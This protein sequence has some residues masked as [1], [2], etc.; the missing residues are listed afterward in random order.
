MLNSFPFYKQ[1][2]M[3]DCGPSCLRMIAKYHGKSY[4]LTELRSK[5]FIN[6][7][8]VSMLGISDAAEAIGF[9]TLGVKIPFEKLS[10]D[11]PLPCIVH[12][13]QNHFAVVYCIK[14]NKVWVAD[15][16]AGLLTY[17][18]D[19]FL[20][21]WLS[22]SSNGR[23]EGVALLLETTP[24]FYRTEA[25]SDL[26]KR[27]GFNYLLGYLHSYR[28]FIVQL[29]IGLLLG[30]L[31]QLILPFLTQSVVDVG[32][33]TRNVPFIYMVLAGQLMLFIGRTVA[34]FLRRWI[35]L[36]LSTR[37]NL[38]IIS[39]F[40]IKL[41]Q[42]P[43]GFFDSKKI[44]D[45]LQRI[46]DHSRIERFLSSSSL[47]ILFSFFNLIVFGV[48]LA[49]Y[50]IPIFLIFFIASSLYVGYVMLFLKMRKDQDYKRFN[51]LSRNRSSL[52]QLVNGMQEIKLNNAE[53]EKRWEWER[54]QVNLFQLNIASTRLQQWQEGGSLFI[55]ELKNIF[56]TFL[57]A[58]AVISGSMTLG[59]MLAVQYIIGQ[60]NVPINEFVNFIRELQDARI[61]LDR[62]GE[63]RLLEN[64]E[65]EKT[66][67]YFSS[68]LRE[69]G[70]R[71]DEGTIFLRNLSYQYD[72][73]HSP[74][75]L[76]GV[77]LI[78]EQGKVTAIVGASGSG[79]TTLL[80][81]LLK[82]YPPNEG[83]LRIGK[84]DLQQHSA[85]EWRARCGTVM[86]DGFIFSDSIARNICVGEE[87]IDTQRL[88]HAATVANIHEF[89]E[90]LPLGYN[91]KIG[92]DGVG[93]SAGQKQRLLIARAVYKNPDYIFFDEAT[94]ALDANNERVIM[95]N[96]NEFF[97]GKTVVVIAHRLS[98]VKNAD[99]IVVLD[100]GK[101]IEQ[102]THEEL[103]LK[104]G[105]YFELVKNQLELGN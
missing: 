33:N 10:T 12:W 77:D 44:G 64:E 61:S 73:P 98:T 18:K 70:R 14:K 78:I 80:K 32:I 81:L 4:S 95:D 1:L 7:E 74:K 40:L 6:R 2:D 39:D 89:V 41:M 60:L 94:S 26:N 43:M 47:S 35:L 9:R 16:A 34:E 17:T 25:A 99:K 51:I 46:E 22:T 55:N 93:I 105:S 52:I 19:E 3:M 53:R 63:I 90:S 38:S 49:L 68:P 69:A 31:I 50:N 88:L 27:T 96:L 58:T 100:K 48:V 91:T 87:N 24:T 21:C 13:N 23:S 83:E 86:Q 57:A 75:A 102:G 30:S 103:A 85:R 8:G 71:L 11:A 29:L 92:A 62:I 37:I 101:L 82:F 20:K 42:L 54:I 67:G 84:T 79:K 76:D 66:L 65:K 59:M 45:I 28:R 36:H 15:P 5:S 97:K 56:I 72:G 104:K